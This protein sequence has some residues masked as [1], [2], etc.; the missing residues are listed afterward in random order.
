MK[1]VIATFIGI[2]IVFFFSSNFLHAANSDTLTVYATPNNLETVINNDTTSSG[3]QAHKVY[4]LVSLD[5]TY[6][7]QGPISVKSDI[8]VI[9]VLGADGRP[10]CIQPMTL[11]DNSLP[12]NMFSLNGANTNAVFKN[13]YLTGRSTDNTVASGIDFDNGAGVLI[14]VAAQGIRLTVDNV[15][16][17]DWASDIIGYSADDVSI[18]V[19]NCVFRNSTNSGAWYSGEALR[20]INN[21]ASSDSIVMKYN[22]MFCIAYS[23]MTPVTIAP[24]NYLEFNHNSVIYT[25][26]NPFWIYNMTN[27]KIDNNLFYAAFSGGSSLTEY[28]GM[29]DQL[30]SFAITGVVDFD[31]LLTPMAQWLDPA[32]TANPNFMW[33]AEAKRKIEVKNND[34]FWP[35]AITDFWTA[36]NDTAHVDSIV[37]PVWMNDRTLGMFADK[38]HW[39]GL[40]QSDNLSVDPQFGTSIN[41]VL[42]NNT[43]CGDGFLDY[44]KVVRTN[45]VSTTAT[46]GYKYSTVGSNWIPEWP[47]P[48]SS[49]MKYTNAALKIGGTDGLPVGDPNWFGLATGVENVPAQVPDKFNLENAYPNPF[50]PS[51]NIKFNLSK[52]GSVSLKVYNVM[53]Q[54]VKTIVDNTYKNKGEYTYSIDMDNF[55]SGVY[56]YTLTQGNQQI[57]KKMILMK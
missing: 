32:D 47:L 4:K 27:G 31:T 26:K 7:F 21:T 33:L 20:N 44:F 25:F 30:R 22:T 38:T 28:T 17:S 49:L 24:A 23:C 10:P 12:I 8:T 15:I 40:V 29:W 14:K 18:F 53:G 19:T 57:T 51:T 11:P 54:L 45:D 1:K 3:M 52:A 56:F 42:N 55:S 37:T 5:T 16:F 6:V 50:N 2:M 46:F 13:L 35:K 39:P 34:C 43:G 9:G 41:D 36:W 48:E